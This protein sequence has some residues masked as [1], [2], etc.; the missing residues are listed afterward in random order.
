MNCDGP[1]A[2]ELGFLAFGSP[3]LS[4]PMMESIKPMWFLI[5]AVVIFA[6]VSSNIA[7]QWTPN[8]YLAGIIGIGLA[9]LL[10]VSWNGLSKL[11]GQKR[12]GGDNRL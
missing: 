5:Q 9:L 8:S 2:D 1:V 12:V 3:P 10:T 6:V 4:A 11:L 7:H